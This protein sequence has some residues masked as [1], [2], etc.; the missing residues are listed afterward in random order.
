MKIS[1]EMLNQ[2]QK[3][4]DLEDLED[5]NPE[6][7]KEMKR[8]EE[9]IRELGELQLEGADTYLSAFAQLK[10]YPFFPSGSTL[11]LSIRPPA[12]RHCETIHQSQVYRRQIAYKSAY[13]INH[14]LQFG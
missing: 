10:S 11:V 1:P 12:S 3:I 6:W 8:V 13:G 7:E 4:I 5:K 2:N 9:S 14:V